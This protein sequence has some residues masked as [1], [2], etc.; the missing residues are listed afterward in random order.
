[1]ALGSL[2]FDPRSDKMYESRAITSKAH[3]KKGNG[4]S[5]MAPN[6]YDLIA[7]G[8]IL[9]RMSRLLVH[10]L[11]FISNAMAASQSYSSKKYL[12]RNSRKR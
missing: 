9:N 8:T 10:G 7:A 3:V 1:M 5:S 2:A 11:S 6:P 4:G 12:M